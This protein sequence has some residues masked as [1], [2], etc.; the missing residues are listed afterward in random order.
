MIVFKLFLQK[1]NGAIQPRLDQSLRGSP[2]LKPFYIKTPAQGFAITWGSPSLAFLPIEKTNE[3]TKQCKWLEVISIHVFE[4]SKPRIYP[5]ER[6]GLSIPEPIHY[7]V[8]FLKPICKKMQSNP[9]LIN[10]LG[11]PMQIH[12]LKINPIVLQW[13]GALQS[14]NSFTCAFTCALGNFLPE[15]VWLKICWWKK[16]I[17]QTFF[18]QKT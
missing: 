6:E 7:Y 1:L 2:S 15:S 5:K 12:F 17:D 10:H 8:F 9:E 4:A 3:T 18:W 16:V 14:S 11:L 13:L